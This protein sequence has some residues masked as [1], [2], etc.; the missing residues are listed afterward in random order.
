MASTITNR[1]LPG[2][3]VI[4]LLSMTPARAAEAQEEGRFSGAA[5]Q[6]QVRTALAGRKRLLDEIKQKY[7]GKGDF[8]HGGMLAGWLV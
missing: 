5:E 4:D 1:L 8:L 2:R 6:A 3:Q 7:P